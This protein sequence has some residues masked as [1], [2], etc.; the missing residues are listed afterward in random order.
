MPIKRY[1]IN[2]L[3]IRLDQLVWLP[4]RVDGLIGAMLMFFIF[5]RA[6]IFISALAGASMIT[7]VFSL[8]PGIEFGLCSAY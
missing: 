1:L 6:L 4:Y 2:L 5:D 3:G 8:N 7:Q